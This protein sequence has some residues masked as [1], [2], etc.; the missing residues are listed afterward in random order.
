MRRTT[1]G[2]DARNS[3]FSQRESFTRGDGASPAS[4]RKHFPGNAKHRGFYHRC[5]CFRR[6]VAL[7]ALRTAIP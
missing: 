3:N 1:E 2:L 5:E 6:S 7:L 4:F